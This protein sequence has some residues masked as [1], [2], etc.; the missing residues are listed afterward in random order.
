MYIYDIED[1]GNIRFQKDY[2]H[3]S[4]RYSC[5]LNTFSRYLWDD[6]L[7]EGDA[8]PANITKLRN[9]YLETL[10]FKKFSDVELDL[11]YTKINFKFDKSSNIGDLVLDFNKN[12]VMFL[13]F[14]KTALKWKD[15]PEADSF[16]KLYDNG[17]KGP[18]QNFN[19][20]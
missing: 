20:I 8:V 3:Y 15:S 4:C 18:R 2:A 13:N 12:E 10:S 1:N 11:V 14:M 19:N 17:Q 7:F 6:S 9:M 16:F 5:D